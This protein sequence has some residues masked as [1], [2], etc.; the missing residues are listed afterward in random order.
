MSQVIKQ[1]IT[2]SLIADKPETL[3]AMT[4]IAQNNWGMILEFFDFS[5]LK[6]G[7]F[8]CWYRVPVSAYNERVVNGKA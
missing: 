6:N 7:K 4:V 1:Y 3:S 5:Q 2:L 8:I